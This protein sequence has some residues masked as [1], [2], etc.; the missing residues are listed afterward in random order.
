MET[1]LVIGDSRQ[2][3]DWSQIDWKSVVKNVKNLRKRIYRATQNGQWN[4]VRSLTKLMLRSF[5]N[6]IL[7]VRKVTQLNQG[8]RT[9]GVDKEVASTPEQRVKLVREMGEHTLWKVKPTKRVYIP[10]SNGKQRPLGIPTIKDRIAQ[11]VVKN[12]LEPIWEAKFEPNSYGF[13]IGR[14]CHD[15]IEQCFNRLTGGKDTWI[16]DADI[17]GFF[18][19]ITHETILESIGKFPARNLIK[20]WLKAGYLDKGKFHETKSGTPQGGIISPLLANIGLH[21]LEKFI[22]QFKKEKNRDK[23]GFIRYADDFIVTAKSKEDI[24]EIQQKNRTMVINKGTKTKQRK[25]QNCS[26]Q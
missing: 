17:T 8:K 2:L 9:A 16:L 19:N 3:N 22:K 15:A 14:S 21:G 18:D 13:R 11:A 24:E 7:S 5:D 26:H 1:T 4:K 10:K 25:N 23:Y 6:L 12:A 20:L